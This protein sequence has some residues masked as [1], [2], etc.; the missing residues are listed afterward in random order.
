MLCRPQ[1][2]QQLNCSTSQLLLLS[3]NRYSLMVPAPLTSDHS[4]LTNH[5][6]PLT[7]SL[8]SPQN[9]APSPVF[10][11]LCAPCLLQQLPRLPP[12]RN[13]APAIGL[14]CRSLSFSWRWARSGSSCANISAQNGVTTS[15]TIMDGSSR[16]LPS[17][18][19]GS[20]GKIGRSR[21]SE[22]SGPAFARLRRGRQRSASG[23][24]R[25]TP[26]RA[27]RGQ[28]SA[29]KE[30]HSRIEN[31]ESKIENAA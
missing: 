24:E 22:V 16:S 15:N 9:L 13:S 17:T 12:L 23:L 25:P 19:S 6:S 2:R 28:M 8:S 7:L 29:V 1:P 20:G 26:R 18:F 31:R 3:V 30:Q 4:P 11:I 21:R 14:F 27:V 10:A 5:F